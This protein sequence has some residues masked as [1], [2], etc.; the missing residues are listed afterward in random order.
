MAVA[1]LSPSTTPPLTSFT[2]RVTLTPEKVPAQQIRHR[3]LVVTSRAISDP[4]AFSFDDG[5]E[6]EEGDAAESYGCGD[7]ER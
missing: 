3:R 5:E 4:F 2:P 7:N 1:L 6:S